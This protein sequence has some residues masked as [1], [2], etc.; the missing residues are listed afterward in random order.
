MQKTNFSEQERNG[1]MLCCDVP[2]NKCK[3]SE[4]IGQRNIVLEKKNCSDIDMD[5]P[6]TPNNVELV[7][8]K[9]RERREGTIFFS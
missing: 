3:H 1:F 7:L 4:K 5:A 2:E 6:I 8:L 9:L